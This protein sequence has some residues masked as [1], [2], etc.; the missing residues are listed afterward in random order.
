MGPRF[1]CGLIGQGIGR[2]LTPHMHEAEAD[3][4][5]V[6]YVYRLIDIDRLGLSP[7]QGVGLIRPAGQLGFSGLNITHPC[8]QLALTHVDRLSPIAEKIAAIN[9]VVFEDGQAVG[10]NTD[11]TGFAWG[12]ERSMS[13]VS[14]ERVVILGAGGAGAAVAHAFLDLGTQ[15]LVIVDVDEARA[16]DVAASM[17]SATDHAVSAAAVDRLGDELSR[18]DG[19]VNC[20]PIGMAHHPGLPFDPALLDERHW[21]VDVIYRPTVTALVQAARDRGC[22]VATGAGMAIGQAVDSFRLMTGLTPDPERFA[23]AF[24]LLVESEGPTHVHG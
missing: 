8:K 4:L 18:A 20:T 14:R 7:E 12:F 3:R 23:R 2:S 11:V 6:P 13:D 1:V 9:T 16:Q 10:H 5:G 19:I 22:R 21:L 24:S 17:R 15:E